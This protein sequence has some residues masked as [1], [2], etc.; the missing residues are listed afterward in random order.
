M[1]SSSRPCVA[2][3]RTAR[4]PDRLTILSVWSA[5]FVLCF[6]VA[7]SAQVKASEPATLIQTVDGTK[8]TLNYSRP[9]SRGR[10]SLFGK[11]VHWGEVWTPGANMATTLETSKPIK[12]NG[13]PVPKGKYSVWMVV[14]PA[15]DWTFVLDP[16]HQLFHEA[17]PD[18][19]AEQIR[20]PVKPEQR[21]FV[22]V[23]SWSFPEI[24]VT[25]A[26]LALHWGTRYVPLQV[27]VEPS[28]Q[29]GYSGREPGPYLGSYEWRWAMAP[30]SAKPLR[31]TVKHENGRLWG[32]WEPDLFAG[33]PEWSNPV[34]IRIKDDWFIPAFL[35]EKGEILEVAKEMVFEF[36]LLNGRATG[37]DVRGED[38]K[39]FA[40]AIRK[41]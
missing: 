37:I 21:P 11:V 7:L 17:H 32:R 19:T 20:F 27:E 31:F 30:D 24:R 28:Y 16:R 38:D 3:V 4:S 41:G 29:L 10:D 9:R 35:D 23:L 13:H 34:L 1:K 39:I 33:F 6:P 8:L 22:D 15:G 5:L 14:R 12:L 2:A 40:T 36:K 18:S 25:G 26:T